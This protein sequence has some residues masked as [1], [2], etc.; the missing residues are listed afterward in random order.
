VLGVRA[1]EQPT[2]RGVALVIFDEQGHTG[3]RTVRIIGAAFEGELG[4]DQHAMLELDGCFVHAHRAVE[5]IAIA[6]RD[7]MVAEIAAA[8]HEL[9]GLRR[10]VEE[11]K[12]RATQ[13]LGKTDFGPCVH[14]A[15]NIISVYKVSRHLPSGRGEGRP[16][17]PL[18][19][20]S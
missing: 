17:F 19:Q 11:R 6:E 8:K 14:R 1:R 3:I 20:T 15:L 12:A 10:S 5:P 7:G 2:E 16:A 18:P 9:I 13:K 4:A